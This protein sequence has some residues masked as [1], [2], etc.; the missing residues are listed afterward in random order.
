LA[1]CEF[2][3]PMDNQEKHPLL[4]AAMK[5]GLLIAAALILLNLLILILK[6]E[7][8][9]VTNLL[10]WAVTFTALFFSLRQWRDRYM[11]GYVRYGQSFKAGFL[12]MFFSSIVVAFFMA[13]YYTGID[14]DAIDQQIG[15]MEE[16]L[17]Q[18][19]FGES[20]MSAYTD[21]MIRMKSPGFQFFTGILSGAISGAIWSL[22]VS[23]FVKKENDPFQDAMKE[24]E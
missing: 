7:K 15:M 21:L 16:Q 1:K 4:K 23:L 2:S 13:I 12:F 20:Q 18:Q 9:F 11:G 5:Y 14:P 22:I 24:V 19:G 10:G 17:Y 8:S 6:L 3:R